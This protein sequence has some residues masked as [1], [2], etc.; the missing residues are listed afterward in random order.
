[1]TPLT[2]GTWDVR[3][4][5]DSAVSDRPQ[6]RT[7]L[8]GREFDR[9]KVEITV[10]SLAEEGL[11]KEVGASYTFFWS[12]RKKTWSR[13]RQ[14][15]IPCQQALMTSKRH[16]WNPWWRWDPLSGQRYASILSAFAPTMTNQD[17]VK[18]KFYE[19]LDSVI[20]ATPRTDKLIL[21]G[22]FMPEWAQTTKREELK[23]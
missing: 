1:M 18:D 23:E 2:V 20:S 15:V 10:L 13:I 9:Y 7:A 16:K 14:R 5:I 3:T 21:L 22:D 19:Y 11:L 8:V 12:G 4:L 17:E 6:R